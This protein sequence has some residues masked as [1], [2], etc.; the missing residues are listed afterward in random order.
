[1]MLRVPWRIT[2]HQPGRSRRRGQ[3]VVEFALIL[4]IMLF[5]IAGAVDIGRLFFA[6]VTIENAAKEGAFYGATNP[7]CDSSASC[8]DPRNVTWRLRQDLSGL[9]GT[10]SSVRCLSPGGTVTAANLCAEGYT[11]EVTVSYPFGLITPI[12]SSIVGNSLTLRST[13]SAIVLN[14]APEAVTTSTT[15]T[16]SSTSSTSTSTSSTTTTTTTTTTT[17]SAPTGVTI[18]SSAPGNGNVSVPA[19]V[20]FTGTPTVAVPPGT[21]LWTFGD[22]GTSN[23]QNPSHTYTTRGQF[24]VTLTVTTGEGLTCATT[25]TKGNYIHGT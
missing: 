11:Y 23:L 10:S 21:Y 7:S 19:T 6:Y 16:T 9:S 25:V 3:S 4:P 12:A 15:S 1:M 17:C 8:A 24:D 18:S 13:E 14:S 20:S 5:L 22:G 2:T